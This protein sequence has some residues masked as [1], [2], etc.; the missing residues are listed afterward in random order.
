MLIF[1]DRNN[2]FL[3]SR[4]S[5]KLIEPYLN[6]LDSY[7]IKKKKNHPCSFRSVI[8]HGVKMIVARGPVLAK[9]SRSPS[10]GGK[11]MSS[12]SSRGKIRFKLSEFVFREKRDTLLVSS[13]DETTAVDSVT[14][15]KTTA[16]RH[17]GT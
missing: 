6:I 9:K 8:K 3:E 1:G 16:A 14:V 5:D 4:F 11:L 13:R 10:T 7:S 15:G 12:N 2:P 17:R